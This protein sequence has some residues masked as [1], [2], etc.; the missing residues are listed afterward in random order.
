MPFDESKDKVLWEKQV[1]VD[2]GMIEIKVCSYN[3][4]RP[5]VQIGRLRGEDPQNL[6]F[7]KLGRLTAEELKT[8]LPVLEEASEACEKARA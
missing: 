5:K 7:A 2:G 1:P 8:I 4:A 3:N 6:S